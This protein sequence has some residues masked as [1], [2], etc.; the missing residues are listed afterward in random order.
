MNPDQI[1]R[2][3]PKNKKRPV[4]TNTMPVEEYKKRNIQHTIYKDYERNKK[5]PYAFLKLK[6][7]SD[8]QIPSYV[9][10]DLMNV[11]TI[12]EVEKIWERFYKIAMYLDPP[13]Q[14]WMIDV[15]QFS[16]KSKSK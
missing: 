12:D 15:T 10:Q 9:V 14:E 5:L 3:N 2:L 16:I 13:L 1:R 6:D 4:L 7:G 11:R 8:F